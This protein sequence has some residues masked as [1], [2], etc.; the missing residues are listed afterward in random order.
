M[1]ERL[2]PR[3]VLGEIVSAIEVYVDLACTAEVTLR[4]LT[5]TDGDVHKCTNCGCPIGIGECCLD[6]IR[7]RLAALRSPRE[8][9]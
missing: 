4:E 5:W 9:T 3:T 6:P 1:T 7:E 8:E 2:S